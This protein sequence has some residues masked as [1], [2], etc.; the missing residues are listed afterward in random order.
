MEV[1]CDMRFACYMDENFLQNRDV[2]CK[3]M[4]GNIHI[5]NRKKTNPK[6]K[7]LEKVLYCLTWPIYDV[8]ERYVK[9]IALFKKVEW[10]PIPHESKITIEDIQEN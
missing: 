8:I 4:D 9:Y 7:F 5:Y 10:K 3:Y 6:S 1:I 2:S